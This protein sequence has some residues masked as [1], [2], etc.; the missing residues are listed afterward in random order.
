LGFLE[1]ESYVV[2]EGLVRR[3]KKHSQEK[4]TMSQNYEDAPLMVQVL[5]ENEVTLN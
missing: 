2:A 1:S 3:A 5:V 4:V